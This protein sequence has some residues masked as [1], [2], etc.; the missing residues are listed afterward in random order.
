M[1]PLP[2]SYGCRGVYRDKEGLRP[3]QLAHRQEPVEPKSSAWA[4]GSQG[5]AVRRPE[6]SGEQHEARASTQKA[7][8]P[9]GPV[10]TA[11]PQPLGGQGPQGQAPSTTTTPS[12]HGSHCLLSPKPL[13]ATASLRE[14]PD[15]G[16]EGC[17]PSSVWWVTALL[18]PCWPR[19]P[20]APQPLPRA[21]QPHPG[22]SVMFP[23]TRCQ[24]RPVQVLTHPHG[25]PPQPAGNNG[26]IMGLGAQGG[27]FPWGSL[28]LHPPSCWAWPVRASLCPVACPG[29]AWHRQRPWEPVNSS[30]PASG[31]VPDKE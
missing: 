25:P 18:I 26:V 23:N 16:P 21:C 30:A 11:L 15:R 17:R 31:L 29:L 10:W 4:C 24:N 5:L 1:L 8:S 22:K 13:S 27:F 7:R 2:R 12:S 3:Q 20:S 6:G 19:R 9:A 28:S 14:A